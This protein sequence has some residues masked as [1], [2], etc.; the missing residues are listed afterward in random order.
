MNTGKTV[1]SQIMAFLPLQEFRKCV[2]Q[3]QGNYK[4]QKFSCYDQFL[5]MAFAQ[6]TYRES[7]RDIETC[8][9]SM[10]SKLYHI[11]FRGK[12]SRSTLADANETRNCQIYA[13]FAQILI[14]TAR[15]LYINEPFSIE[16][17]QSVYALDAT[18]IKLCLTL[19]PWSHFRLKQG[20]IKLHTLLDLRGNIPSFIRITPAKISDVTILDHL[21][22]EPGS[23]YILD[24]GYLDF[25]RMFALHQASAFFVVR[26]RAKTKYHRIYS[27][28]VD[29]TTGLRSDQIVHI[30][31]QEAAKRYPEKIRKIYF[32]DSV[33]KNYLVFLTNNFALPAITIA[34]LY[35]CRWQIELFFKWI[36]QHL[37]IKAFYGTSEN[38]VKTQ[39]WI[40]ISI[41][42]LI[43]IIKKRLKI[44]LNLYTILQIFSVTIFEKVNIL[45]L[46]TDYE[47][48][49]INSD[50]CNQLELFN[51]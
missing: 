37:R 5:C 12:I 42:V 8:L 27:Q 15:K 22:P 17:K 28:P 1:F 47:S 14:S 4:V 45:Q 2:N 7:L 33:N 26:S 35:K 36:K 49:N 32:Y 24:R 3:Y 11:G 38:A 34:Q 20:A 10:Q 13:D 50:F 9:R 25:A 23:F 29:K 41:Y 39:I 30:G 48:N 43:A 40:A 21:I 19:F 6:L 46:L 44:K 31:T 18:V 51:L 16:L